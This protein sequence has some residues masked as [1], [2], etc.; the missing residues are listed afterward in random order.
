MRLRPSD[1]YTQLLRP[2]GV[3]GAEFRLSDVQPCKIMPFQLFEIVRPADNVVIGV[4]YDVDCFFGGLS[5]GG[6]A[7]GGRTI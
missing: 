3:Y 7:F 5:F 1:L 2:V 4:R 6:S